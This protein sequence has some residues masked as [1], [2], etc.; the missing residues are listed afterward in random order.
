MEEQGGHGGDDSAG[1]GRARRNLPDT[2]ALMRSPPL[3]SLGPSGLIQRYG[4]A[5]TDGNGT[6]P[7]I[8]SEWPRV[9]HRPST[10]GRSPATAAAPERSAGGP[11]GRRVERVQLAVVP[12][13][14]EAAADQLGRDHHI[15]VGDPP[16]D[17][18]VGL[19]RER[20]ELGLDEDVGEPRRAEQREDRRRRPM[21]PGGLAG[22]GRR[23]RTCGSRSSRRAGPRCPRWIAARLVVDGRGEAGRPGAARALERGARRGTAAPDRRRRR[24]PEVDAAAPPT[25]DRAKTAGPS[26]LPPHRQRARRPPG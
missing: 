1:H 25:S 3:V 26:P 12:G 5:G 23:A 14:D 17:R 24:V 10:H 21:L 2:W 16:G 8:R 19:D 6:C 20:L 4:A 13:Q 9:I 22:R 7:P 11:P 15:G 18:P